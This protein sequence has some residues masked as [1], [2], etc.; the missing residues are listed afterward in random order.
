MFRL[1]TQCLNQVH[2]PS[3][4]IDDLLTHV[5]SHANE[6][7]CIDIQTVTCINKMIFKQKV[8]PASFSLDGVSGP[9]QLILVFDCDRPNT[10]VNIKFQ[11]CD[12]DDINL[13]NDQNIHNYQRLATSYNESFHNNNS[14]ADSMMTIHSK[15]NKLVCQA[16]QKNKKQVFVHNITTASTSQTSNCDGTFKLEMGKMIKD[17]CLYVLIVDM[18]MANKAFDVQVSVLD[19]D[20]ENNP[21]VD[22]MC[23]SMSVIGLFL[24][25]ILVSYLIHSQSKE[26]EI[27][28][29]KL[30]RNHL[31]SSSG[32]KKYFD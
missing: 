18:S 22:I 30:L 10:F 26:T 3:I 25:L 16:F 9:S 14:N 6:Y 15:I 17:T 12:D 19:H 20:P 31:T 27:K 13:N 7:A 29:E 21:Q 2:S 32:K 28:L 5:N 1:P 23:T 24:F 11:K 4:V 8:I